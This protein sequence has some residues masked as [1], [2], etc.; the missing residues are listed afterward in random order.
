MSFVEYVSRKR[1]D[2]SKKLLK[3]TNLKVYEVAEKLVLKMHII[4]AYV[5]RNKRVKQ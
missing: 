2:A 4:F 3:E 5:L 1:I